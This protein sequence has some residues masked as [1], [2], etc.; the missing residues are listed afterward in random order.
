VRLEALIVAD[1][2]LMA[3]IAAAV[4]QAV[5]DGLDQARIVAALQRAAEF[6]EEASGD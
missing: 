5:K 6:V 1:S 2:K 3:A 4:Q